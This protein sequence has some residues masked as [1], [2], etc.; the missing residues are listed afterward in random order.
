MRLAREVATRMA[1]AA[2]IIEG[3]E[4]LLGLRVKLTEILLTFAAEKMLVTD[5]EGLR[6]TMNNNQNQKEAIQNKKNR[7]NE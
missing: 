6:S 5:D 1:C 2:Q 4:R 7:S 3:K